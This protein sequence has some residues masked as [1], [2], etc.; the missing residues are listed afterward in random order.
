MIGTC[1]VVP[2][3]WLLV[4]AVAVDWLLGE[5]PVAVHPVAWIGR[6]VGWIVRALPRKGAQA[7]VCG[8]ALAGAVPTLAAA[9]TRIAQ[10]AVA[11]AVATVVEAWLLTSSF[12]VR[13]LGREANK[14]AE[15]LEDGQLDAARVRLGHLCSR[16]PSELD[17]ADVSGAAVESVA[18]NTSDSFVA[19]V[20]WFC[21][22]GL[23]GAVAF[24]AINTL[25]AMIGYRGEFE[26]L[27]KAAARLD[28][29]A[30]WV[31]ARLTALLILFVGAIAGGNPRQGATVLVRDR[32]LTSSPN[33]G[34]PMAAMAGVLGV[35]LVKRGDYELGREG[36][37]PGP[38]TIR[39]ATRILELT[40]IATT[41]IA[42]CF[43]AL[44]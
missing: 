24:R 15:L 12:S 41:A 32:H 36:D 13:M 16:D 22:L 31:P 10:R 26:R 25:D 14:I 8:A 43:L 21:I 23:P 11:P 38:S 29:L 6:S 2:S 18:E 3:E 7:L 1:G 37:D 39:D 42:F 28:D 35:R 17:A 30:C 44:R 40:A 20:F 33:A 27:G 19:P 9:A 4:L 5:C 34:S